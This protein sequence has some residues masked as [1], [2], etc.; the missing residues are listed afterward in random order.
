[1]ESNFHVRFSR[2]LKFEKRKFV[3]TMAK[4]IANIWCGYVCV[5]G[6][7]RCMLHCWITMVPKRESTKLHN[8]FFS[9][10]LNLFE[11]LKSCQCIYMNRI[12]MSY[13]I[14]LTLSTQYSINKQSYHCYYVCNAVWVEKCVCSTFIVRKILNPNFA[15]KYK[16][17][18]SA[19][20]W[21][22]KQNSFRWIL[23]HKH[24]MVLML[25]TFIYV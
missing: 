13:T 4:Y 17:F 11:T 7:F 19:K 14:K 21:S 8:F 20:H 23:L 15:C 25:C 12:K 16:Y 22:T 1:M 10:A 5:R 3:L 2:S 24:N 18:M 9:S 6:N